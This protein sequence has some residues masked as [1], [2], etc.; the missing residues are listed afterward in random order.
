MKA[1]NFK[2]KVVTDQYGEKVT[3]TEVAGNIVRTNGGQYHAEKVFYEGKS[4]YRHLNS[5][6]P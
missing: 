5:T 1:E 3:I 4:V 6:Q 2:G